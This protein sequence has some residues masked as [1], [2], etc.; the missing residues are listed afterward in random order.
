MS[1]YKC[2]PL[3]LFLNRSTPI[4]PFFPIHKTK[5]I[6]PETATNTWLATGDEINGADHNLPVN[7]SLKA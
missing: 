4:A 7:R 3:R 2:S 6:I 1:S 5:W